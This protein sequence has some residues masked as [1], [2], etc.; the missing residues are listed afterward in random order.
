MTTRKN[1][2]KHRRLIES[3]AQILRCVKRRDCF[4]FQI[5]LSGDFFVLKDFFETVEK[6]QTDNQRRTEKPRAEQ[7]NCRVLFEKFLHDHCLLSL[8]HCS[9]PL[10]RG[11][12]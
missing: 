5:S 12:L 9:N 6:Y 4:D 11:E 1:L 3:A 8:S 7:Q 10:K 2:C